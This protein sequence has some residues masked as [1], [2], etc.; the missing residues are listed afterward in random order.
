MA[1]L[2]TP[3]GYLCGA[4]LGKPVEKRGSHSAP[5]LCF[6]SYGALTKVCRFFLKDSSITRDAVIKT[7]V[8]SGLKQCPRRELMFTRV[9]NQGDKLYVYPR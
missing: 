9:E 2:D 6:F 4:G 1:V 5:G 8:R 7:I 3:L